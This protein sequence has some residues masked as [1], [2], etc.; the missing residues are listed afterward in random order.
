MSLIR[1]FPTKYKILYLESWGYLDKPENPNNSYERAAKMSLIRDFP[2]DIKFK[3]LLE[4]G[5]LD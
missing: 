4:W 3:Y 2:K 1:D 5:Y